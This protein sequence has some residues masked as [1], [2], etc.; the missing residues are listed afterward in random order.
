MSESAGLGHA[1]FSEVAF[2]FAGSNNRSTRTVILPSEVISKG[3][4]AHENWLNL[5]FFDS[6]QSPIGWVWHHMAERGHMQLAPIGVHKV[7][8]PHWGLENW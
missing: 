2:E 6:D 8:Q 7:A 5:N 4:T 3:R 1:D